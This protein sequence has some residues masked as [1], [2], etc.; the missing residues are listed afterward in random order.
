MRDRGCWNSILISHEVNRVRL[1][2]IA[3]PAEAVRCGDA[4]PA[5]RLAR[6]PIGPEFRPP[7]PC[8]TLNIIVIGH[9]TTDMH[10]TRPKGGST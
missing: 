10:A 2:V 8:L 7:T 4:L 3:S 1:I 6:H 9:F 5:K